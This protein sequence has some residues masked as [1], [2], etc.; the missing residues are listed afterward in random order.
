L[1]KRAFGF[2][3]L[4]SIGN[5]FLKARSVRHTSTKSFAVWKSSAGI[6]PRRT[7]HRANSFY[8]QVPRW[9]MPRR[10]CKPR[11]NQAFQKVV[12]RS[13]NRTTTKANRKQQAHRSKFSLQ[14]KQKAASKYFRQQRPTQ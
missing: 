2:R 8:C 9:L 14:K 1:R 11:A 3:V 13:E 4:L 7:I 12:V 5:T 10:R 6:F